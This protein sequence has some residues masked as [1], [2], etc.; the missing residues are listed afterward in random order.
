MDKIRLMSTY[1]HNVNFGEACEKVLELA[2][3]REIYDYVVTPNVDHIVRLQK[4]NEFKKIY[5]NASLVLADGMPLIWASK[6]LNVPLKEKVSGSDIFPMLCELAS[7]NNLNVFFLGGLEGVAEKAA[8]KLKKINPGL[9]V[10]GVYSPPFGFEN[11]KVENNKIINLITDCK[12][13]ILFVGLGSPKQ[14]KWIYDNLTKL[15]VPVSLGIGASFDFVA[16]TIK[17]APNWM[18]RS[19]LE[20]FWRFLQEP[21]RLFKRYFIE[22]SKFVLMVIKEIIK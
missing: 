15:K 13:D 2:T 17:R 14:E 4:D 21:K 6:L 11:N 7:L 16:E 9:N 5:D 8:I 12:P 19:G 3:K 20:W 1:I 18:Q 22:D 10:V